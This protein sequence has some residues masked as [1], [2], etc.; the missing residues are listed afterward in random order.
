[1]KKIT[2]EAAMTE[3][4][5]E[6]CTRDPNLIVFGDNSTTGAGLFSHKAFDEAFPNNVMNMP[7]TESMY[8]NVGV[9][10]AL[11]GLRPIVEFDFQD[12]MSL[13][14]DGI[15]NEA[16]KVRF[17]SRGKVCLPIVF[18]A[19]GGIMAGL[20][21]NHSQQAE[22]WFANVPGVKICIP[23]T[24][25]DT[26]GLLKTAIRDT[27]PVIF[28]FNR[29][30]TYVADEVPEE[31]YTVP[32]GK[33][34]IH[35]EGTDVT[36]VCWHSAFVYTMELVDAL[37]EEGISV[38]VIDPLT[39]N[40]LDTKT[41]FESVKK[42]GRLIVSHE[43][44]Y[45]FGASAEIITQVAEHCKDYLKAPPVRVCSPRTAVPSGESEFRAMLKRRDIAEAIFKMM[46]REMPD[47][48]AFTAPN[49]PADFFGFTNSEVYD[50]K[51]PG[52][53]HKSGPDG[54][55]VFA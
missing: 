18:M 45:K 43:A 44:P 21:C 25:A 23:S 1:M 14:F 40:P 34:R 20:G 28:L 36:V 39:L 3:A 22:A 17:W 32:M 13:G 38:E 29:S 46:G 11:A 15:V 33:A 10:M 16:A 30:L 51:N 41:I 49:S 4:L 48:P 19:A 50:P 27:D 8:P 53:S 7:V 26:K 12:F 6:E 52:G 35:R 24:A 54:I 37:A 47:K 31:E 5:I 2:L 55:S 9:G 42:T